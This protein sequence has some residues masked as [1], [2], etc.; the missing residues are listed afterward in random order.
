M[1]SKIMELHQDIDNDIADIYSSELSAPIKGGKISA[2]RYRYIRYLFCLFLNNAIEKE[3]IDTTYN[4]VRRLSDRALGRGLERE[5]I[6]KHYAT[7]GRKANSKS[8]DID[9]VDEIYDKYFNDF[10]LRVSELKAKVAST[11][12]NH[13]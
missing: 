11:I 4:F 7:A 1:L 2:L 9:R 8:L 5:F 3:D 12:I 13:R 10:D 6:I